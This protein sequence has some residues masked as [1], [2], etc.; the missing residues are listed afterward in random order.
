MV[1]TIISPAFGVTSL[2]LAGFA[3]WTNYGGIWLTWWLGVTTGDFS[4]A[5][6]IIL[7]SIASKRRWNRREALE[8]GILLLLLFVLS[9]AVFGGW[10]TISA[11]LIQSH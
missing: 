8:V 2:A 1:S 4:I 3:D 10:L 5:P 6:L 7:W 11:E 9:E